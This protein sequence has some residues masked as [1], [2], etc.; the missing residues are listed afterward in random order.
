M[1]GRL[2]QIGS[3]FVR[4]FVKSD[5]LDKG[6][7]AAKAQVSQAAQ[8]MNADAGKA[9]D[10]FRNVGEEIKAATKPARELSSA[11]GGVLGIFGRVSL[12]IGL[13]G[14]GVRELA[15][16]WTAVGE[17]QRKAQANLVGM[18]ALQREMS[19]LVSK[20]RNDPSGTLNEVAAQIALLQDRVKELD[21]AYQKAFVSDNFKLSREESTKLAEEIGKLQERIEALQRVQGRAVQERDAKAQADAIKQA[22]ELDKTLKERQATEDKAVADDV[23]SVRLKAIEAAR[24]ASRELLDNE[25]EIGRIQA[26]AAERRKRE[27]AEDMRRI[28]ERKRAEQDAIDASQARTQAS[29]SALQQSFNNLSVSLLSSIDK[30]VRLFLNRPIDKRN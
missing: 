6:L 13:I 11:V 15:G 25:K 3:A 7:N 4:L 30:Q 29:I 26:E 27:H 9:A 22:A 23:L 10:G 19:E 18:L 12:T 28:E 24:E 14:A 16:L 20:S 21:D 17:E 1:A 5:E 8:Q 2:Q